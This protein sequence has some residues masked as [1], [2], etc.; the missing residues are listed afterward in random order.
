MLRLAIA[1]ILRLKLVMA[2]RIRESR[3]YTTC[4]IRAC[5]QLATAVQ[6]PKYSVKLN[7]ESDGYIQLQ[8]RVVQ[9]RLVMAA[10]RVKRL[11]ALKR[12]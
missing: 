12:R 7:Q 1:S 5:D 3:S 9:V 6:S 8:G 11:L 2:R 10:Y 4:C